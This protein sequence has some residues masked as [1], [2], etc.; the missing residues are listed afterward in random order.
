VLANPVPPTPEDAAEF[1]RFFDGLGAALRRGDAAFINAAFDLN[2]LSDE[3][4]RNGALDKIPILERAN[5]RRGMREGAAD[6]LGNGMVQ[7]EL[8]RWD[9]TDVKLVRWSADRSE[10]VA[11]TVHR[12][13]NGEENIRMKMR[14]WLV[15]R[16]G[17]WRLYDFEDLDQGSRAS[18]LMKSIFAGQD[19]RDLERRTKD[20]RENANHIRE[21]MI[22]VSKD[23]DPDAAE[24]ALAQCRGTN[25]PKVLTSTKAV[26]EGLILAQR[27]KP[28]EALEKYDQAE[29]IDAGMPLLKYL[30]ASAY[31]QLERWSEA[32]E[33]GRAYVAELGPD[34]QVNGIIGVAL[35]Q[36]GRLGE[37]V[38]TFRIGL[39]DDEDNNE[40]LAGL[41]RTLPP[42]SKSEIVVRLEKT[43][44][45]MVQFE[46]LFRE[47]KA[48]DDDAGI[49]VLL[50]WLRKTK[51]EDIRGR[52]EEL[53]KLVRSKKFDEAAA[54]LKKELGIGADMKRRQILFA[55]LNA[56]ADAGKSV[57]AYE[58]VPKDRANAAFRHVADDLNELLEDGEPESKDRFIVRL[59]ALIAAHRR[60]DP[61]DPWLNLYEGAVL[62]SRDN[63]A[64]AEAAF[65]DGVKRLVARPGADDAEDLAERLR[66]S[67]VECQIALKQPLR[68]YSA[69]GP[70][71]AT[72][73]QIANHLDEAND[74][75]GLA[76]VVAAH[77]K[78]FPQ[79]FEL[80]FWQAEVDFL[81][82]RYETAA[83][84]FS[85]FRREANDTAPE[86]HR[87][88]E[89]CI[90]SWV[91]ANKPTEARA[92][93]TT[94][95]GNVVP[96]HLRAIVEAAAGNVVG[97]DRILAEA[98]KNDLKPWIFYWD[99]DFVQ[100]TSRPAFA[101]LRA[102]YP[103]PRPK[104]PM[105]KAG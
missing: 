30:R 88:E 42:E 9:R 58:A 40:C 27:E 89:R 34:A 69:V 38:E 100:L 79:A 20:I 85:S 46:T 37:A 35:E 90:R 62:R 92:A 86:R 24:R 47:A 72:F 1:G 28:Q 22:A 66:F 10:A 97:V 95:G 53:A 15:R 84:G 73:R 44:Q 32:L 31:L 57:E 91:R 68:A 18:Q 59:E 17:R 70:S 80:K 54:F 26:I 61:G 19:L 50:A 75:A 99:D 52:T 25:M 101:S 102:K 78:E 105:Q 2:R 81:N 103:D 13:K 87:A 77:R 11:I 33:A 98:T 16:D 45:P 82:G 94:F 7:N 8:M 76:S 43:S 3:L 49:A 6:A 36:L 39:D 29:R 104:P 65:T 67:R 48:D 5:F 63:H 12:Q 64:E 41:L 83:K 14:W 55:Y 93:V 23:R 71:T 56:M 4:F 21:A 96:P 74:P 51:P 60:R